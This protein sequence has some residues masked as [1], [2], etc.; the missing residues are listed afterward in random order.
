MAEVPE[1]GRLIHEPFGDEGLK[2]ADSRE[3]VDLLNNAP[4][5]DSPGVI[6]LGPMDRA[7]QM[8]T[9]VLLKSIEE[10]ATEVIRPVLWAFNEGDVSGTIRSRCL[11]RWCHA[12]LELDEI[13][14]ADAERIVQAALDQDRAVVVEVW[15]EYEGRELAE[16]AVEVLGHRPM[17][18]ATQRLWGTLREALSVRGP[19]ATEILVAFL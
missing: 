13:I 12:K 8:A 19:T 10:F 1:I 18:Q 14:L 17:T 3:I 9:D 7:Q 6:V 15:R 2:I 4:V 5:G 16:A 11:L